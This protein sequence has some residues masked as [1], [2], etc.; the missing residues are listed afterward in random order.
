MSTIY[1]AGIFYLL[2]LL[3]IFAGVSP[4]FSQEQ[5]GLRL[6]NYSGISGVKLNPASSA[7]YPLRWDINLVGLNIFGDNN[8]AYADNT[9]LFEI[10]SRRNIIATVPDYENPNSIPKKAVRIDFPKTFKDKFGTI[11]AGV[12]GPSV[13]VHTDNGH[14]FG[15]FTEARVAAVGHHLPYFLGWYEYEETPFYDSVYLKPFRAVF[16]SWLET[17]AHY[18]YKIP[19]DDG[20]LSIGANLKWL[21]GYESGYFALLNNAVI[22]ELPDDTIRVFTNGQYEFGYTT[23]NLGLSS[24]N[25]SPS[26]TR[27]GGGIA[28]DLGAVLAG[29]GDEESYRWKAGISLLDFGSIHYNR[30]A[31]Q[32]LLTIDST[33]EVWRPEVTGLNYPI[34]TEDAVHILSERVLQDS[35][36]TLENNN[37]T[38]WSP[39]AISLQGEFAFNSHVFINGTIVQ[40]IPM[41]TVAIERE[42]IMALTPRYEHR[43]FSVSLPVVLYEW[44]DFR[45]GAAARL[46]FLTIG[47]D[48]FPSFFLKE[49]VTGTDFYLALKVTPFDLH[50]LFGGDKKP[51]RWGGKGASYNGKGGVRLK[52][53]GYMHCPHF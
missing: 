1:R 40:R 29:G 5:L 32:H 20:F 11:A 3:F 45:F 47:T 18:S 27:N 13:M 44:Q 24:N 33:V 4:V 36:A 38:V 16:S 15:L 35:F 2:A 39:S 14:S 30:N 6:E 17:G 28:F 22:A 12:S 10:W 31:K 19:T 41:G 8:Y 49:K 9:N 53:K 21:H 51:K 34:Q 52:K 43:W 42:N 25:M 7:S 46:G 37:F 48:H 26:L 50:W 23:S